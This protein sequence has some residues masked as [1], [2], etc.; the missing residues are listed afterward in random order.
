MTKIT[1]YV[2]GFF[3]K[4]TRLKKDSRAN[5]T[6]LLANRTLAESEGKEIDAPRLLKLIKDQQELLDFILEDSENGVGEHI[7]QLDNYRKLAF[8]G[9]SFMASGHE[10]SSI[11]QGLRHTSQRH[12]DAFKAIE[13]DMHRLESLFKAH[14]VQHNEH[15]CMER[16]DK[17]NLGDY[18]ETI[19]SRYRGKSF[20]FINPSDSPDIEAYMK[21]DRGFTIVSNLVR[22]ALYWGNHVEIQW[23]DDKLIVSDDGQGVPQDKQHNL[24]A[25]GFSE[26]RHGGL[27]IGLMMCR[28]YAREC[29]AELYFDPDNTYTEL[30]GASFVLDFRGKV[31]VTPSPYQQK[32]TGQ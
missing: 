12:P 26:R 10:I 29:I 4:L 24:F 32:D 9:L 22:N 6:R 7:K 1:Q 13:S 14:M 30:T 16:M 31:T 5:R 23:I 21:I 19:F 27:G 8:K 20:T 25:I 3:E 15:G 2:A 17:K 11:F 18:I 28:E